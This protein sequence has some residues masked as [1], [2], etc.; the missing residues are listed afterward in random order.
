MWVHRR[1]PVNTQGINKARDNLITRVIA[2]DILK[3][4]DKLWHR[5]VATQTLQAME[6]LEE[7]FSIIKFFLTGRF[8]NGMVY[9]QISEAHEINESIP[10]GSFLSPIPFYINDLFHNIVRFLLNIYADDTIVYG[11]TSEILYDQS[12]TANLSS[13]SSMEDS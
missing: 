9:G 12:L 10:Q 6:S 5:G 8:M 4:F 7:F 13:N 1:C 11:F 3:A 2:L